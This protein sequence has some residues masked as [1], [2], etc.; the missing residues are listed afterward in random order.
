MFLFFCAA[1]LISTPR[2]IEVTSVTVPIRSVQYSS[3]SVDL[4]PV[5]EAN[6]G[7]KKERE[8][9]IKPCLK[10]FL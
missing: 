4:D 2:L 7:P 8:K 6:M 10:N 9:R 5:K 1:L 3:G